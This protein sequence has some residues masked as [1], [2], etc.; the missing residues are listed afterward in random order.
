MHVM[1]M[2]IDE[3]TGKALDR[4]DEL[5]SSWTS[6][7]EQR[8]AL[9]REWAEAEQ[10]AARR[11]LADEKK[12][13]EEAEAAAAKAAAEAEEAEVR[14]K[15]AVLDRHEDDA[16]EGAWPRTLPGDLRSCVFL[17]TPPR[18]CVLLRR[19]TRGGRGDAGPAE[20]AGGDPEAAGRRGG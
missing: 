2:E 7:D 6:E 10:V 4:L 13:A 15:Q 3:G 17:L 20:A 18:F 19:R 14:A 1:N 11:K 9:A 8:A 5:Q 16:A 12:A